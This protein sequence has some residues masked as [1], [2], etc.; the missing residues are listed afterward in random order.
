MFTREQADI[1]FNNIKEPM[2]TDAEFAA[3]D[4]SREMYRE[5]SKVIQNLRGGVGS[6]YAKLVIDAKIN[7]VILDKKEYS[8]IFIG[9]VLE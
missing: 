6:A 3:M 8:N 5:V 7:G 9:A 1:I 2:L 4:A